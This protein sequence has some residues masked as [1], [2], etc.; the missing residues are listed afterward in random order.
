M[1]VR[2]HRVLGLVRFLRIVLR[3]VGAKPLPPIF[4]PPG[5]SFPYTFSSTTLYVV[6][7]AVDHPRRIVCVPSPSIPNP[8]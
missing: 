7:H 2:W 1:P 3:G 4:L 8:F 5:L 6:S